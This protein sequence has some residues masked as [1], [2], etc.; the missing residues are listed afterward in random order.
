MENY[1]NG[2]STGQIHTGP[3][4]VQ[5]GFSAE[6]MFV[7][8]EDREVLRPL[9]ERVATLA[10]SPQMESKRQLWRD[11]NALKRGRPVI[12]CE[13]E[14]GWNEIITETQ[15]QCRG[16]MARHWEMD[17]R[18]EI[19]IGEVMGDD[20]PVEAYFN[21]PAT[22]A[23]DNWGVEVV[24]HESESQDGAKSWDPPIKD[25][26]KDLS[27]LEMPTI[28]IDWQTSN[29]NYAIAQAVLGDILE[30]RQ[31]SSWFFT[32]GITREIV[33]L[34]GLMNLYTDFYQ[35]PDGLKELL[36]FI[37]RA[38]LAKIDF[39]E[40]NE[41]LCLNN[42]GTYVGSGGLGYTD[43]LPQTGFDGKVRLRDLWGFTESQETVNVSPAMYEEFVF[44]VEKPIMER[45]G[46]TCYG[47]CE[48]LHTRWQVVKHHPNLRRVSCSPWAD[49]SKMSANLADQFI[50]SWKPMPT[51]LSSPNPDWEAVRQEM[52]TVF[53]QTRENIVEVIMKDNHTLGNTPENVVTW[54]RIAQEE[55]L[56][57]A[58]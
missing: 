4:R 52:R 32:L 57:V 25:Y 9:A 31:R 51:P 58:A 11:V 2:A 6:D 8:R 36:G 24:E 5:P 10:A 28:E 7:S 20:R 13:P 44:P 21:V 29:K 43:E 26:D 53:E 34:R 12:L 3:R 49:V 42:D 22:F 46:L 39:L 54:C 45:F 23:T 48:E 15:M 30:V 14:N 33:K 38:N 16:K 55:A 27:K 47:C 18:K 40:Q 37:S 19:F 1:G 50:F 35:H 56:R 17:L 41:L